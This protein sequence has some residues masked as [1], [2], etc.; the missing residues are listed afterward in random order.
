MNRLFSASLG[1]LA[2]LLA[3]QPAL[4]FQAPAAN[5]SGVV[6][7]PLRTTGEAYRPAYHFTPPGQWMNDPN[8]LVY[9][10]GQ[11]HLF[12]QHYPAGNVWGPMHWGHAVSK[13]M[14][15]WQDRPIALAPDAHGLIFSGSAVVDWN[16]ASGLGTKA[17]PPLVAIYTYHNEK[18]KEAGLT[19]P[20]SQ[21][22][23]YSTDAGETWHK[24]KGNPVLVPPEGKPDFRDP[25]VMWH[26][27]SKSWIMTLAVGDHTEFY[28]SSDLK[29]WSFLSAFGKE[30]GA[31]GGVWECPDLLP[32]KVKET[33]ETKWVLIQ[34]LNPGGPNGGSATQ[35][36]VGDFDG[37]DFKLDPKYA[38]QLS[39]KGPQWLDWGRDNYAGVTWS[40]VPKA[41]GRTLMMGW[42]NNWD[43]GQVVPTT[44]WRGA[45][46][47]PRE[48]T[49]H[50][51][52]TNYLVKSEPAVEVDRLKGRTYT[53]VPQTVSEA[54]AV[55]MPAKSV[56]QS[57]IDVQFAKPADGTMAYLELSNDAGDI[58]K[59]GYDATANSFFSDRRKSGLV[60]F[61]DKFAASVHSAPR[62][63]AADVIDMKVFVDHDSIELFA[64]G[65]AT[66]LTD[67]LYPRKPYTSL[68]FVAG[69]KSVQVL[70]MQVTELKDAF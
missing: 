32:M 44:A 25:K 3:A 55:D 1:V 68:R 66:A 41:D 62:N 60:D 26:P 51:D 2:L 9:Y 65:G 40:D 5:A 45:M 28:R 39:A 53:S 7:A 38:A 63:V 48:L 36:F 70:K 50:F 33:G 49:L 6:K 16:N 8:G 67:T 12:Y 52:G 30:I 13:D 15:H 58:Y 27:A 64:D 35:Y 21:G 24:Y 69:G 54:L 17:N 20:Q 4:A 22:I 42:M 31:H 43:Y 57:S 46:T 37:R 10:K 29:S 47:L 56:M 11:Y 59:I 23:A 34:S 14:V 19:Y 18:F 61:S